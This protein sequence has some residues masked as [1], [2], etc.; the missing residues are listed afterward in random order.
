VINPKIGIIKKVPYQKITFSI[1]MIFSLSK[2]MKK[3]T[4]IIEI[5]K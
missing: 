4:D 2:Y 5:V 3:N 1:P